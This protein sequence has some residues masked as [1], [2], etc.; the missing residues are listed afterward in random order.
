ME[1][2]LFTGI[3][4]M[5]GISLADEEDFLIKGIMEFIRNGLTDSYS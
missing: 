2:D 4:T 3:E 5:F 1:G